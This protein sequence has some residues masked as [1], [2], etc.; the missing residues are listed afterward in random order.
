MVGD[1]LA[2]LVAVSFAA[3]VFSL[4]KLL[5]GMTRKIINLQNDVGFL[6]T[7]IDSLDKDMDYLYSLAGELRAGE[8]S[9]SSESSE[10]ESSESEMS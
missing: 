5:S 3:F 7:Q 8:S 6:Q 2:I 10:S 9:E 1:V 4:M